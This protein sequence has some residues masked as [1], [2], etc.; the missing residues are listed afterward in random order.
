[1]VTYGEGRVLGGQPVHCI[2]TN[3]S[4]G[5]SATAELLVLSSGT[6]RQLTDL[7]TA[8]TYNP[9]L[10]LLTTDPHLN[11]RDHCVEQSGNTADFLPV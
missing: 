8:P 1:M 5:L 9:A 6:E 4:R 7:Q 11:F 10:Q 2:C 3:A